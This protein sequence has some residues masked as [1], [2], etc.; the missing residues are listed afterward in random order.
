MTKPRK[1]DKQKTIIGQG[2]TFYSSEEVRI[3][4]NE[5][6]AELNAVIKVRTTV[7]EEGELVSKI[8]ETTI[9]R[10]LFNDVVPDFGRIRE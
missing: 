1:T 7:K 4:Y 5:G 10:V 2:L 3:A 6:K 9:G 8:I